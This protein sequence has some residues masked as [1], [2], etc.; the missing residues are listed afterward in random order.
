M[1]FQI[2]LVRVAL[3]VYTIGYMSYFFAETE[4]QFY[5]FGFSAGF[6]AVSLPIAR[7]IIS[8]GS[9]GGQ[10]VLFST[11]ALIQQVGAIVDPVVYGWVYRS[12]LD[13][14][15][16]FVFLLAGGFCFIGLLFTAGLNRDEL[17]D[18]E[19]NDIVG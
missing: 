13:Y 16:G 19:E 3:V 11:I 15:P 18:V 6:G 7:G 2:I 12:T 9:K 10:G 14:A 8:H 4:L 1:S 17:M 5:I